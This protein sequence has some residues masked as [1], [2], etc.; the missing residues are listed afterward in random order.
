MACPRCGMTDEELA[1]DFVVWLAD[2][3]TDF[4]VHR[5]ISTCYSHGV[6]VYEEGDLTNTIEEAAPNI[7]SNPC[8]T[9]INTK[10]PW[11]LICRRGRYIAWRRTQ[12]ELNRKAYNIHIDKT[13]P[14]SQRK[15]VYDGRVPILHNQGFEDSHC[16]VWCR[17]DGSDPDVNEMD[18]RATEIVEELNRRHSPG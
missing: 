1:E 9:L 7:R 2:N 15:R 14:T 17:W 6:Q 10:Y 5:P 16:I 18:R 13:Q 11:Q 12:P 4:E 8:Q 3:H